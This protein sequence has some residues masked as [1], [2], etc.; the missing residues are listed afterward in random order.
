[1]KH[2]CVVDSHTLCTIIPLDGS[3]WLAVGD[4][5]AQCEKRLIEE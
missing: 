5:T 4:P 3:G 2:V 1:M